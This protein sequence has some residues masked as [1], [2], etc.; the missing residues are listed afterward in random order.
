[1]HLTKTV[2]SNV[3]VGPTARYVD[4]KNNYERDREPI[5]EFARGAKLL[6]P[7]LE[8]ADLVTAYLGI[9][10]KLTP[11]GDRGEKRVADFIIQRDPKFPCVVHLMGIESPGLTSAPSIA[12]Q[13]RDLA[14]DILA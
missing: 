8:P 10:A 2:W 13:V 11:P 7:E 12:E 6:L 5:D 3:L 1:M 14:V 9:R 4:D